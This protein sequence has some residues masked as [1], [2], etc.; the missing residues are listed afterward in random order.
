MCNG[1]MQKFPTNPNFKPWP[2]KGEKQEGDKQGEGEGEGEG[3][4]GGK[5]ESAAEDAM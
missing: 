1:L 4:D 3:G 5:K 2:K